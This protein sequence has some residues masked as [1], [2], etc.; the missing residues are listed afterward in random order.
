M[1][2]QGFFFCLLCTS[3]AFAVPDPRDSIIVES[4]TVTLGVD[5]GIISVKVYITNKD[6][7]SCLSL[8]LAAISR[9][10]GAYMKL[11]RPRDFGGACRVLDSSLQ[12]FRIFSDVAYHNVSPDTILAG[13]FYMPTDLSTSEAPNAV[14]KAFLELLFD[15]VFLSANAASGVM[16]IDTA[17][18]GGA[19][20][21]FTSLNYQ[22]DGTW[23]VPHNFL[24]G[25]ITINRPTEPCNDLNSDES[26]TTAD[27][28]EAINCVFLGEGSCGSISTAADVVKL[29]MSLYSGPVPLIPP[30][31]CE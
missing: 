14:R 19:F 4:K 30:V 5:T 13:F 24:K 21:D 1:L 6:T 10:N 29:L 3:I 8:G 9:T 26:F 15:S 22:P 20:T 11:T 18:M 25:R 23:R 16:E 12:E 7:L 28:V 17:R 31:P 2:R 27:V